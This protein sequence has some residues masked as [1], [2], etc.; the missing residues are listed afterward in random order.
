MTIDPQALVL[1]RQIAADIAALRDIFQTRPARSGAVKDA[2]AAL[3]RLIWRFAGHRAFS[4]RELLQHST[5][6]PDF[7]TAILAAVRTANPRRLGRY[8]RRIEN[9]DFDGYKMQC[10]GADRDGLI[11]QVA[12]SRL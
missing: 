5:L 2:D 4:A 8:F 1:L 9:Q 11:W 7:H 3:L 12:S 10:L 6:S